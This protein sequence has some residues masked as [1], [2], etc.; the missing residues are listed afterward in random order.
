MMKGS[1]FKVQGSRFKVQGSKLQVQGSEVEQRT[2]A[3]VGLEVRTDEAGGRTLVGHAAVF[4]M[5]SEDLWGFR[6]RIAPGAFADVL[7]DDVRALWN[8][9]AD[10]VLGR[11]KAGT[12]RIWE[13]AE[14]LGVEITP[15]DTQWAR[16]LLVSIDRGDVTQMSFGFTVAEE[17][18]TY[19]P[20]E[21]DEL[22]LRTITRMGELFDVSPVTYPAYPQTTVAVRDKI[23]MLR[24]QHDDRLGPRVRLGLE[25]QKLDL[26][27]KECG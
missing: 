15:P 11:T 18:W 13:D 20:V 16:D 14:G 24:A 2:R 7:G 26:L 17:E 4:D 3:A 5:L 9:N 25:M 8:H 21:S 10:Y 12:L 22:P 27:D 6:E 1:K 23:K 19:P